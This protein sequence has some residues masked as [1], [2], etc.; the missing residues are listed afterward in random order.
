MTFKLSRQN[1]ETKTLID[2]LLKMLAECVDSAY[3]IKIAISVFEL[4]ENFIQ[5]YLALKVNHEKN[6]EFV[7]AFHNAMT[8]TNELLMFKWGQISKDLIIKKKYSGRNNTS[9]VLNNDLDEENLKNEYEDRLCE[10]SNHRG[11]D[12]SDNKQNSLIK[13]NFKMNSYMSDILDE[14]EFKDRSILNKKEKKLACIEIDNEE[15]LNHSKLS[16][17]KSKTKRFMKSEI[18]YYQLSFDDNEHDCLE[19]VKNHLGL[20]DLCLIRAIPSNRRVFGTK[21]LIRIKRAATNVSIRKKL[22]KLYKTQV[23][24]DDKK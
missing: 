17:D 16:F 3:V 6:T 22:N 9:Y 7:I 10:T 2:S 24:D 13:S 23:V 19:Y 12:L 5:I 15:E 20:C 21:F 18:K 14:N 8:K 4:E 1:F 11:I